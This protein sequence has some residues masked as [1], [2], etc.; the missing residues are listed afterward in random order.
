MRRSDQTRP[1]GILAALA[2]YL[3]VAAARIT[4]TTAR[5]QLKVDTGLGRNGAFGAG[6]EALR[7]AEAKAQ[8][9][10]LGAKA[11]FRHYVNIERSAKSPGHPV[12]R[13]QPAWWGA[14][15]NSVDLR[16]RTVVAGGIP[17]YRFT[18]PSC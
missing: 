11:R 15:R 1:L 12:F 5:V 10:G 16:F 4:G 14:P 13:A 17:D 3:A 7:D 2:A 18:Q 9:E 8:A 6:W